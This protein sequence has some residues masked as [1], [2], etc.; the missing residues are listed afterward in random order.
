MSTVEGW[1][2]YSEHLMVEQGFG[3]KKPA[4]KLGQLAEAL[5]RMCRLIVGIR[6]HAEDLSVEQGVRIFRDEAYLEEASARREAERGTFDPGYVVYALGKLMLL[7]L[8]AD[9]QA[10][11][12]DGFS[13]KAFH[14][15]FLGNGL[16]PFTLHRASMLGPDECGIAHDHATHVWCARRFEV[17]QK[18]SDA[19]VSVCPKCG[20]AV[21]KL[22]SSPAI[23][24]KGTGWYITVREA[25]AN[26]SNANKSGRPAGESRTTAS[27]ATAIWRGFGIIAA[28]DAKS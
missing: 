15:E 13:L 28:N 5:I 17:I 1:A 8:R 21:K 22:L 24:F 16:V 4:I 26:A 14:D 23:Q 25:G 10:R 3:K 11:N 12:G 27:R 7:K 9:V 18:Y 6:L 19:P 20:G 2:H